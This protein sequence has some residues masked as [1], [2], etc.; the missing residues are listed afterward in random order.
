MIT[1]EQLAGANVIFQK[2]DL[3]QSR[4]LLMEDVDS[5]KDSILNARALEIS[6]LREAG[7]NYRMQIEKMSQ[8]QGYDR[9]R[10]E[11]DKRKLKRTCWVVGGVCLSVGVSAGILI[12][13]LK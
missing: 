12:M 5:V 7:N 6:M 13:A 10:Y 11:Q 2:R 1:Q 4:I 8:L 9:A 3:L